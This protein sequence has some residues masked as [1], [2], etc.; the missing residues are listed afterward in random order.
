MGNYIQISSIVRKSLL[1][2]FDPSVVEVVEIA[3][4]EVPQEIEFVW[5]GL[6]L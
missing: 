5:I 2:A 1:S 6:L 3:G 4:V